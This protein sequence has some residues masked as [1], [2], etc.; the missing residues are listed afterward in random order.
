MCVYWTIQ[1]CVLS[2]YI[3]ALASS[4]YCITMHSGSPAVV[5]FALLVCLLQSAAVKSTGKVVRVKIPTSWREGERER[6][7]ERERGGG[8]RE[9]ERGGGGERERGGGE[10]ESVCV[11]VCVCVRACMYEMRACVCV[12]VR[13]CM[14]VRVCLC[15]C[16]S[17]CL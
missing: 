15:V 13:A 14:Y 1:L 11:C 17:V 4:D 2:D 5:K 12:C 8:E 7:R 9:R 16:M 3:Q 10:R 6:D